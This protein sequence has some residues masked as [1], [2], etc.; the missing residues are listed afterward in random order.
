MQKIFIDAGCWNGISTKLFFADKLPIKSEGFIAYGIDPLKKYEIELKE[1]ENKYP[2][3]WINKAAW[4]YDGEVEF[5]EYPYTESSSIKKEKFNFQSAKVYNV[6][7]FDFSKW[8]EQFRDDYVFLK[9]NIEGAEVDILEKMIDDGTIGIIDYM[10][11]EDHHN[12][13]DKNH[14]QRIERIKN[15]LP[16]E[17]YPYIRVPL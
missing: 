9:M 13:L 5:G 7:C 3:T 11:W 16:F 15:K 10:L 14:T 17:Y 8:I 6:P 4:T 2:F 12:K 1:L